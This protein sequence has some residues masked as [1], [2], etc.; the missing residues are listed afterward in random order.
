MEHCSLY[1]DWTA[2]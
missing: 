2:G 1:K